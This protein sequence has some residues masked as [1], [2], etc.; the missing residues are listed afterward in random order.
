MPLAVFSFRNLA[1]SEA[2]FTSFGIIAPVLIPWEKEVKRA[3][4]EGKLQKE[5]P[6]ILPQL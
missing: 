6:S 3:S 5:N 4:E 1:S 2:R